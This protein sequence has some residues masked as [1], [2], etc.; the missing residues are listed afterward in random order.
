MKD[1]HSISM[2]ARKCIVGKSLV[3][4]V[5]LPTCVSSEVIAIFIGSPNESQLI[6]VREAV[7]I[8]LRYLS[9]VAYMDGTTSYRYT[10]AFSHRPVLAILGARHG[11][12]FWRR[13]TFQT[14]A[15]EDSPVELVRKMSAILKINDNTNITLW[16]LGH[17]ELCGYTI[18]SS[19]GDVGTLSYFQSLTS[20]LSSGFGG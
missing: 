20:R 12:E 4:D 1:G 7:S 9:E 2:T 8:L 13:F 14:Q 19:Y 6:A 17:K 5:E 10:P 15:S 16:F 18:G 3:I 11:S